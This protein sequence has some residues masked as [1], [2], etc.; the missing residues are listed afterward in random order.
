MY[1]LY[2]VPE[3]YKKYIYDNI[4]KYYGFDSE[5]LDTKIFFIKVYYFILNVFS[6]KAF[7]CKHHYMLP[8]FKKLSKAIE[9]NKP[10][11]LIVE[12]NKEDIE[13][14][15]IDDE[16]YQLTINLFVEKRG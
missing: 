12:K 11:Y 16:Q 4:L 2:E 3:E 9:K 10:I 7:E 1:K 5:Y 13:Y 14:V 6:Y 8:T 15:Q